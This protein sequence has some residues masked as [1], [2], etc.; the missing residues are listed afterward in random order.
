MAKTILVNA[1]AGETRVAIVEDGVLQAFVFEYTIGVGD[2]R[3]QGAAGQSCI[4]NIVVGRVRRVV[5][6]TNAAFVDIGFE[7]A[8]FLAARDAISLLSSE[9]RANATIADCVREG[10]RVLVQI[11]KDPIGDKGAQLSASLSLPGRFLVLKPDSPGI[12]V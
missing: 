3:P 6:A 8:G 9:R 10:E 11:T 4:G 12:S 7:R 1:G 5:P 2:D